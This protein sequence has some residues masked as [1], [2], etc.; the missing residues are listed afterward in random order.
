MSPSIQLRLVDVRGDTLVTDN[1]S[2]AEMISV[3]D[4]RVEILKSKS[5]IA[6]KGVFT[7]DDA[8]LIAVPDDT[9]QIRINVDSISTT[10]LQNAF[11]SY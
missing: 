9:I 3:E 11:P 10:K 6:K 8:L 2:T 4:G 1:S 7:F 5:V